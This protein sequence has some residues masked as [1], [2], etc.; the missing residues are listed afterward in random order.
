M[1]RPVA[2]EAAIAF[3]IALV[4][5]PDACACSHTCI[6]YLVHDPSSFV[7]W[8]DEVSWSTWLR[9]VAW[10]WAVL[11]AKHCWQAGLCA[12][13][14]VKAEA[15]ADAKL[16]AW[17]RTGC[18]VGQPVTAMASATA[19]KKAEHLSPRRSSASRYRYQDSRAKG[20]YHALATAR[21][22][23]LAPWEK[24]WARATAVALA[25]SPPIFPADPMIAA[26]STNR[27]MRRYDTT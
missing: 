10:A 23:A 7:T 21:D 11:P 25:E 6:L 12:M 15:E 4:L 20:A 24:A 2:V 22:C 5:M 26:C 3:A 8:E 19:Y 1:R 27:Q 17:L 13:A 14:L 9:A 16:C 18:S